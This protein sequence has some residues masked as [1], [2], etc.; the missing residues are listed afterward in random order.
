M[1]DL[2]AEGSEVFREPFALA[3]VMKGADIVGCYAHALP[4]GLILSNMPDDAAQS[5]FEHVS[6]AIGM[7]QR[8]MGPPNAARLVSSSWQEFGNA[9]IELQTMWTLW[10][11]DGSPNFKPRAGGHLRIGLPS[12]SDLVATWGTQYGQEISTAPVNVREFLLRKLRRKELYVWDD[13]GP[14]SV[15]SLSAATERGIRISAVYTPADKRGSGYASAAVAEVVETQI[16]QG[17]KFVTLSTEVGEEH[18][19]AMYERLGFVRIGDRHCYRLSPRS[20]E[21]SDG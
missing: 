16:R 3:A 8:V 9:E 4:D 17:K 2:L 5:V 7:P 1:V 12:E 10:R 15:V 20:S 11:I 18:L 19:E 14:T 21:F 6:E 13:E